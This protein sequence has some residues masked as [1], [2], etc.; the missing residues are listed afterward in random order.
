MRGMIA[1]VLRHVT[2]PDQDGLILRCE[3]N[4][5]GEWHLGRRRRGSVAQL[6]TLTA[7]APDSAWRLAFASRRRRETVT[8]A[9]AQPF[10]LRQTAVPAAAQAS[11][12][13]LL[14]YEMDRLTPFAADD[15]LFTYR[16]RSRNAA[17]TIRVDVA[18]VPRLW[19]KDLLERFAAINIRPMAL[20]APNGGLPT[21]GISRIP[22]NHTDTAHQARA[23]LGW[24]LSL[25]LC[26]VVGIAALAIPFIRQV[27]ALA[28]VEERIALSR[29]RMDQ[30]D[31]LRRRIAS[32]SAGAGQIAAA[33]MR[34]AEPLLVLGRLTDLLPDDTYLI[35]VSL[36]QQQMTMEGQSAAATKLIASMASEPYFK[37]PSFAAPVLRADNGKDVF[38]IQAGYGP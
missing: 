38:T 19:V 9:L 36:R 12:D 23:Q 7:D 28:D 37:N 8:I 31:A 34:G 32:G 22:L 33:R 10:L 29:P 30:V 2:R 15:V 13:D 27:I 18:V 5:A 26:A 35:S 17:G 6:T 11:L 16:V 3:P 1:P 21:G 24:R 20:E 25:G 14:R 4:G